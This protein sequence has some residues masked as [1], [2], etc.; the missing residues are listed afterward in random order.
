M[1][2]FEKNKADI[3]NKSHD[4]LETVKEKSSETYKDV[5]H[6]AETLT[7][8]AKDTMNNLYK[9]SKDKLSSLETCIEEYT[10]DMIKQVKEKPIT[11]L[12]IAGGI[13]FV[14]SKLMNQK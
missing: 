5:K 9:G 1:N 8:N 14:I 7:D 4:L 6:K 13:G 11:A 3:K 12:L 2:D 10:H